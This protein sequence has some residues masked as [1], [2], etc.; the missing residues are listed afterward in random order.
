MALNAHQAVRIFV[1]DDHP[2]YTTLLADII[3]ADPAFVAAG[4][5]PSAQSAIEALQHTPVDIVLLDLMLP[6]FSGIEM[7]SYLRT[8][9]RDAR[10]VV[11]SGLGTDEAIEMAYSFGAHAYIEKSAQ[12]EDLCDMLKEVA[13]GKF[14]MT[15]R[16]SRVLRETVRRKSAVKPLSAVDIGILRRLASGE[17][18]KSIATATGISASGIYKA[19]ARIGQRIGAKTE[20]DFIRLAGRLGLLPTFLPEYGSQ[21]Q[22]PPK[23]SPVPLVGTEGGDGLKS[24]NEIFHGGDRLRSTPPPV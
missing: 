19:R 22:A 23:L 7:L 6:D 9:H 15:P 14:P 11:F 5:A 21:L 24:E 18:V 12:I 4:T 2:I 16:V 20:P 1:V 8:Q 13:I 3:G 10:I 17:E